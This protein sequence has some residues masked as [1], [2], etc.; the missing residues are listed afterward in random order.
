MPGNERGDGA[1][2][3]WRGQQGLLRAWKCLQKSVL[4]HFLHCGHALCFVAAGILGKSADYS[5]VL[6]G[7]SSDNFQRLIDGS[8]PSSFVAF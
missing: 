8:T 1:G 3:K 7:Q 4:I 2:G 6:Y 5:A